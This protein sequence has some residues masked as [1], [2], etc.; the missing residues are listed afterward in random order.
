MHA[1]TLT[2][3]LADEL[4]PGPACMAGVAGWDPYAAHPDRGEVT[5]RRCLRLADPQPQGVDQLALFTVDGAESRPGMSLSTDGPP[6][7]S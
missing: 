3:W 1:V 7:R 4:L 2:R 6:W 5:C